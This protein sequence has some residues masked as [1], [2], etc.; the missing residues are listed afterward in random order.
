MTND[1]PMAPMQAEDRHRT[2]KQ[3]PRVRAPRTEP[4][5]QRADRDAH[6]DRNQNGRDVDVLDLALAQTERVLDQRHE[7]RGGEPSEEANEE[8]QPREMER[9][10]LRRREREEVDAGC[11][12]PRRVHG[13]RREEVNDGSLAFR[14]ISQGDIPVVRNRL[15][16]QD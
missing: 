4:V 7:R 9:P 10:H 1:A 6:E 8:R 11:F 2:E 12:G 16:P 13:G 3:E 5:A 15:W 14:R